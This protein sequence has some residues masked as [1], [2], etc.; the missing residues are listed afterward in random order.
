MCGTRTAES[1]FTSRIES[2]FPHT[3]SDLTLSIGAVIDSDP[4][5][6]SW[7]I[8]SLQIFIR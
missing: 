2:N 1:R 8:S 7:G 6:A 5:D 4:C 3:S